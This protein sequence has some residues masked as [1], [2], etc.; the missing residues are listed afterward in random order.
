M[1]IQDLTKLGRMILISQMEFP[2][3]ITTV[4][5]PIQDNFTGLVFSPIYLVIF[6]MVG[7]AAD[8]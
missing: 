3:P 4:T 8:P 5:Q 2:I 6:S 7:V 1:P